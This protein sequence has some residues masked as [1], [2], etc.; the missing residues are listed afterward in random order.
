MATRSKLI[1]ARRAKGLTQEQLAERVDIGQSAISRFE[2]GVLEPSGT[3]ARRLMKAL[4]CS[5]DDVLDEDSKPGR[6]RRARA[7]TAAA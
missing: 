4:G 7:T 5:L 2:T 3:Q 6:G 1:A